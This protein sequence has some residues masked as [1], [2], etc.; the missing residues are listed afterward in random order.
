VSK[1][2]TLPLF[3]FSI[4]VVAQV[5]LKSMT[6]L[7]EQRVTFKFLTK[8]DRALDKI[9]EKQLPITDDMR[10]AHTAMVE[11]A[12]QLFTVPTYNH[13]DPGNVNK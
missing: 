10:R 11:R 9:T 7:D 13:G 8:L 12:A 1:G 4:F 6:M 5:E 2:G 3:I